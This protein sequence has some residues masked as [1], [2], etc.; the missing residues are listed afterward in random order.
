MSEVTERQR[1][2]RLLIV[3][4]DQAQLRTL[5]TIM[6]DEGFEVVGCSTAS[7]ALEHL[8]REDIGVAV[9]DLRLPDLSGT[10]LLEKLRALNDRVAVTINTGY[11]SFGSAKDAV[12]LGAFA[13]VE[14]AGDP[15]ELVRQVHRAFR[16][17]FERYADDLE[18]AVAAR[19]RE[20]CQANE[21]L[22]REITERK[23]AEERARLHQAELAR[24]SR[25]STIGEMAAG[26]AHGLNQPLFAVLTCAQACRL[27]IGSGRRTPDEVLA[28]LERISAAAEEAGEIVRRLRN[29][30]R[31]REPSRST[32]DVN[33]LVQGVVPFIEDDVTRNDIRLRLE[34]GTRIPTVLADSLLLQQVILNLT[35]N[36]IEAMKCGDNGERELVIRTATAGSEMVEVAVRD[37]GPGLSPENLDRLFEPFFTTKSHGLGLGLSLSRSVIEAEGGRLVAERNPD[38][39]MTFRFTLPVHPGDP[40]DGV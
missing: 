28:D 37:T 15:E 35:R 12:N 23:R 22:K 10:E 17:H 32:I 18:T 36:A 11:G 30:V 31:K 27:A 38:H 19:T 20:L 40:D 13:Y 3:E 1:T 6:E 21:A 26:I 34:L 33:K 2:S 9:V 7:A 24:V 5:T 39:G 16:A 8:N 25:L 29:F 14:K 4:D